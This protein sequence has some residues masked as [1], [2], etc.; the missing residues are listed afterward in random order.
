MAANSTSSDAAEPWYHAR[1][2]RLL[3]I[4]PIVTLACKS[5]R[6]DEGG[7]QQQPPQTAPGPKSMTFVGDGHGG[8]TRHV[9]GRDNYEAA[10]R[11]REVANP[12]IDLAPWCTRASR[13]SRLCSPTS[14][15]SPTGRSRSSR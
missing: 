8:A 9:R 7:K 15:S 6:A 5:E 10:L 4:V 12:M 2:Y 1:M 11:L 13:C 3:V 14:H